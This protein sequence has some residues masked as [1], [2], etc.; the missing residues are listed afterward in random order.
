MNILRHIP[1]P[2]FFVGV[3]SL[4]LLLLFPTYSQS[5]ITPQNGSGFLSPLT[6]LLEA[7]EATTFGSYEGT[8]IALLPRVTQETWHLTSSSEEAR[9]LDAIGKGA[10]QR[11]DAE[12]LL[13]SFIEQHPH[14]AFLPEAK[15]RLGEWYYVREN[16][17]ATMHWLRGLDLSQFSQERA[18]VLDYYCAYA[19]LR[20]RQYESAL[21][22]FWRLTHATERSSDALFY[23]GYLLLKKGEK[24]KALPLLEGVSRHPMYG[25]Y[26]RAY[27][28]MIALGRR[29]YSEALQSAEEEL[30]SDQPLPLSVRISSLQVA[31]FSA[32]SLGDET[33]ALKYLWEY[34]HLAETPGRVELLLL[35]KL[36]SEKGSNKKAIPYL[37]RVPESQSDFLAQL[38]HYYL[39]IARLKEKQL[40]AAIENFQISTQI[41]AYA[42]LTQASLY[43]AALALYSNTTGRIGTGS[44]ALAAF[45]K[46]YPNS[47]YT[48]NAFLYLGDAFRNDPDSHKA[49]KILEEWNPLPTPLKK[50]KEQVRLRCANIAMASGDTSKA[51]KEYD[52]IISAQQD[53]SAVAEAHLWKGEVAYQQGNYPEAISQTSLYLKKRPA[54]LPL[55]PNAY[56]TLGFA[57][58]NTYKYVE[59]EEFLRR[60][61]KEAKPSADEAT[62]VL[63]RLGD[64]A[65]QYKNYPQ[66][67]TLYLQAEQKGGA[68]SDYALLNRALLAGRQKDLSTKLDL[69]Q[70]F[71]HRHPTSPLAPKAL[72]EEGRTLINSGEQKRARDAFETFLQ[73]YPEN[74]LA[75]KASLELAL[76][77]FNENALE[78]AFEAYRNVLDKY[79]R[80]PE[81][82]SALQDLK[83]ISIQL[84]KVDLYQEIIN[85]SKTANDITSSEVEQMTFLAAEKLIA[86]QKGD[87]AISAIER[88]LEKYPSSPFAPKAQLSLAKLYFN[89][90]A[91]QPSLDHLKSLIDN[92]SHPESLQEI[93]RLRAK[94]YDGLQNAPEA[95]K[96]YLD[97]AGLES[98]LQDRSKSVETAI[99]RAKTTHQQPLLYAFAEKTRRAEITL[100]E[101]TTARLFSTVAESYAINNDKKTALL[102]AQKVLALPDYNTHIIAS[103]IKALDLFDKKEYSTVQKQM[104][105]LTSKASG[106][107][108]WLARAFI[109]LGDTYDRLGDHET[110]RVYYENVK[111]SY[112]HRNDGIL[113]L[114][115]NRLH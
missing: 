25:T 81:A 14:S 45:V 22:K 12:S 61:L 54:Q 34:I 49:L 97:L 95:V 46:R 32:L 51:T 26:A 104:K 39:G 101:K 17:T 84:N 115:N 42:P 10:L 94:C 38:A 106:N 19:M 29:N 88:F 36:L 6:S 96:A 108:Y 80:S 93:Y 9:A 47:E 30:T 64:I 18:E 1:R 109:L 5:Q 92:P 55:N 69:L 7:R 107:D 4:L 31:G 112:P 102:Y 16:Y 63:N 2:S 41:D 11:A 58:F 60:Y 20:C 21:E 43:N 23:T 89:K 67:N 8:I 76:S 15:A 111:N 85:A 98:S 62:N 79:P 35:G 59:A 87:E 77:F 13:L 83:S 113:S 82:Q 3:G 71:S 86:T 66:A 90:K 73:R 57:Y 33:T 28:A 72:L 110:A 78:Q 48:H 99:E 52:A 50:T 37:E 68:G 27:K 44:E 114:V 65:V 105:K 100:S 40:Q 91:F 75:P 24:E 74:E 56:Y 53:E 70:L 103:V